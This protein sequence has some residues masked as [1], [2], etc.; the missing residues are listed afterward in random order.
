M[1]AARHLFFGLLMKGTLAAAPSLPGDYD[2]NGTVD[3][4]DYV[5]WR[6]V[7]G[8]QTGY[9]TWR[10]PRPPRPPYPSRRPWYF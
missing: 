2:Q 10:E 3:A 5:V 1:P 6:K 9:D 4:A 7:D 8:T